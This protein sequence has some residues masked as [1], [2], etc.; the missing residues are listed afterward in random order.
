MHR[1]HRIGQLL[2]ISL[3]LFV[4]LCSGSAVAGQAPTCLHS[5][6][7]S[8]DTR[9]DVPDNGP[10]VAS[11]IP[12][13]APETA[14][15]TQVTFSV[16]VRHTWR[17]D[18][19]CRITNG[20]GSHNYLFLDRA[21]GGMDNADDV[22]GTWTTDVFAGEPVSQTWALEVSDNYILDRGYIESWSIQVCY[23]LPEEP[24]APNAGTCTRADVAVI[25]YGAWGGTPVDAYV[26]GTR[27]TTL[28][29]APDGFGRQAVRWTFYPPAGTSWDVSVAP[30]L[31]AGLDPARWQYELVGSST[32]SSVSVSR[33]SQHVLTYQLVDSAGQG[34]R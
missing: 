9:V 13:S 2:V 4:V 32:S 34:D 30:Q 27:Q 29:T 19:R 24:P 15:V 12:L 33:C 25:L 14:V 23:Q 31:P 10:W 6:S 20:D 28:Y 16:V 26:G 11:Y 3:L 17:G 8:S 1:C 18:L 7:G 21:S 22:V 5:A